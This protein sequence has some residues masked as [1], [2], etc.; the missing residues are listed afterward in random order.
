MRQAQ[1]KIIC[2]NAERP[3]LDAGCCAQLILPSRHG[4]LKLAFN[5]QCIHAEW[6]SE[7]LSRL[8][9]GEFA[10]GPRYKSAHL[11]ISCHATAKM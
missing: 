2:R 6:R 10:M 5:A 7:S 3:A 11:R 4:W 8:V 9:A 1:A